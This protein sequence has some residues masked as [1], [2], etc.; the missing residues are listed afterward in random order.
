MSSV[1]AVVPPTIRC[2]ITTRLTA[3]EAAKARLKCQDASAGPESVSCEIVAGHN[4]GHVAFLTAADDGA[5]WWWL[6]WDGPARAVRQVDVCDA[7]RVDDAYLDE[8]LLPT[9]HFGQHSF[10]LQV[11]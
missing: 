5:L 9:G 2:G 1:P 6:Y 3:I 4:G 7:R 8:C 11:G 10:D